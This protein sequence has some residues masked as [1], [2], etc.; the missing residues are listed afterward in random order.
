[1]P[2]N[3]SKLPMKN[4]VITRSDCMDA[5]VQPSPC[6]VRK[7]IRF[8]CVPTK[9]CVPVFVETVPGP[10]AAVSILRVL[11]ATAEQASVRRGN[12][13]GNWSV[14]SPPSDF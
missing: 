11:T 1:M 10:P 5:R 6:S 4:P 7:V 13:H 8:I 2:K 3:S 14:H 12:G 9:N